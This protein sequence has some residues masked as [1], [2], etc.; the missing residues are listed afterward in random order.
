MTTM[1]RKTI[2]LMVTLSLVLLFTSACWAADRPFGVIKGPQDVIDKAFAGRSLDPI[3]GIWVKDPGRVVAIVKSS[4]IYPNNTPQRH[5]YY[6]IKI[7]GFTNVGEIGETFDKTDYA[8]C[9]KSEFNWKLLS[10]NLLE[11]GGHQSGA[12]STLPETYVRIYPTP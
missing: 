2:A 11:N 3:E 7:I 8:F 9:F 4:V 5:D 10:P 1:F 6:L 12:Y